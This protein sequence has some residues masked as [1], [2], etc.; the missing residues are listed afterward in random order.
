MFDLKDGLLQHNGLIFLLDSPTQFQI[1]KTKCHGYNLTKR[2][3]K[4]R[5]IT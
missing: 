2:K 5:E 4:L 3:K 1:P